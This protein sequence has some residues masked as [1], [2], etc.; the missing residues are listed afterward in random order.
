MISALLIL[1]PPISTSARFFAHGFADPPDHSELS[2][3]SV[4]E[5]H[6]DSRGVNQGLNGSFPARHDS[7]SLPDSCGASVLPELRG[8]WVNAKSIPGDS[9]G[10]QTLVERLHDAG[11]NAIFV[12]AFYQGQTIYPSA[13]LRSRGMLAQMPTFKGFDPLEEFLRLAHSRSMEIHAWFSMFYVGLNSPGPLLT[14]YP[15]WTA[16]SKSGEQGYKQG[17]NRFFW[18]CPMHPG[19]PEFY[20]DLIGEAVEKYDVD[21]IH[22]DYIR[23]PDPA[24]A[25]TC[26]SLA[27]REEFQKEYGIDPLDLDPLLNPE[28]FRAWNKLRADSVTGVVRA[29]SERV[30]NIRPD[31]ELTCAVM[32]R[33]MP[34][35]L[36]PGF[37][38]DWPEWVRAGY[39]DALIP[40]AYSSRVS[41]MK[42]LLV[43]TRYFA[44]GGIPMY[45]GL[46]GFNLPGAD[47]LVQQIEE[48]RR[49]G[50][51]VSK[52]EQQT[53]SSASQLGRGSNS[54]ISGVVIFAYPY[55]TD[56]YLQALKTGPFATRAPARGSED[57]I[58]RA[59]IAGVRSGQAELARAESAEAGFAGSEP[60][61][62]GSV[63]TLA[64][65]SSF[66]ECGT[67][68]IIRAMYTQTPPI[69]DGDLD[70]LAWNGADWQG[71]FE[72]ITGEGRAE[73]ETRIAVSYDD[74]NLYVAYDVRESA[75]G[76]TIAS[77]IKRDGP[78]FYD[79]SVELFLDPGHDHSFYYH[80][81]VNSLG[82]QY[83][84]Y[85]RLGPAWNGDWRAAAAKTAEGWSVEIAVPIR[86]ISRRFPKPG[87]I[88]GVNFNRSAIRSGEFS[89][90][91][92]TPGTFH[93]PSF[94]GDLIFDAESR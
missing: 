18:V 54:D 10:I 20:A 12:E 79:D 40:M 9:A 28:E 62:E 47:A 27:H 42:G 38:Q 85:S 15:E 82:T 34:L 50:A 58:A 86:E 44:Q 2:D 4:P 48:I 46:Q 25:D 35:E 90:W 7:H 75:P 59:G 93:A 55:L 84:S 77:V 14:R 17:A 61:G 3:T 72:V 94:F 37:L 30:R 57:R 24:A 81:A 23:F 83:D 8:V 5:H 43:W 33:G 22:L 36:N 49:I 21:G 64:T 80:F 11:F 63:M 1:F 56:L 6:P 45:I 51:H 13:I 87:D 39:I 68:R 91:S 71:G 67:P 73:E 66:R 69:I 41:E 53:G 32:P 78:V 70:D 89:G 60:C 88:W 29:I 31:V 65:S 19:V 16:I 92:F 74:D 26:Y 76:S 52:I